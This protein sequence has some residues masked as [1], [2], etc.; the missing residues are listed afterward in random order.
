[1]R[2]SDR[3]MIGN[4][5]VNLMNRETALGKLNNQIGSGKRIFV[6]SDDPIGAVR[7]MALNSNLN[8]IKQYTANSNYAVTWLN[9][10]DDALATANSYLQRVYELVLGGSSSDKPITSLE[11]M[12]AEVDQIRDGLVQVANT[13]VGNSYIFAGQQVTSPT[14]AARTPATGDAR[15]LALHP[16]QIDAANRQFKI[17]LD[18]GTTQTITLT[19]GIYD[20]TPGKTLNDLAADIQKQ[21]Q[22]VDFDVPIYAKA[23]PDNRIVFY[24]G[25]KPPD[26]A[27]HSLV[28]KEVAGDSTLSQL[29][30]YNKATTKELVGSTLTEPILVTGMYPLNGDI[31]GTAGFPNQALLESTGSATDDYYN[32]W[33]MTITSGPGAGQSWTVTG[34]DGATKTAT[35]DSDWAPPPDAT[36]QYSL[37]PPRQG[38]VVSSAGNQIQLSNASAAADFYKGMPITITDGTGVGQTRTITAYDPVTKTATVDTAW[39][40]PPD[41]TSSYSIDTNYYVTTNSKFKITVGLNPPQEISLD[42]GNYSVRDLAQQIQTQIQ[43][44]GGDYANVQV[45]ATPEHQL[46]FTYIDPTTGDDDN[47]LSIKLESGS[48]GDILTKI[49][50]NS[51]VRSETAIPNYEGDQG[52]SEYEVNTGTLVEVN[53]L[54]DQL[55]DPIFQHLT[56][57]SQ[58]LRTGN[59][60][61]LSTTDIKNLQDD[62]QRVLLAQG[63]CGAKVNRLEK[64]LDRLANVGDSV[65]KLISDVEDTDIT[66]AA[67][68]YQSMQAAY[69]AALMIGANILPKSLMDYLK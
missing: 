17:K 59:T 35:V 64:G 48:S 1:M 18:Q 11:D 38:L 45:T 30:F 4:Y 27:T 52:I 39:D 8:D 49:G 54:G 5:L 24:A 15:N 65:T 3:M 46:R 43:A 6:P 22:T 40:S 58:N 9:T 7:S 13:T 44:R 56:K 42:G 66:Q 32:G 33:T 14:Y 10:A 62:M 20:G 53:M 16:I 50:F 41:A 61:A 21:L 29:G 67:M 47:P 69:E 19:P 37:A 12:A 34:Y 60:A 36:S 63:G 2:V 25:A 68:E 55:F 51:G 23:T 57:I 31:Q 26:G 28:L